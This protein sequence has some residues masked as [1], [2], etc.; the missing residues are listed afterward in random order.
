MSS[1]LETQESLK[2]YLQEKKVLVESYY[3][4][5]KPTFE[6]NCS[7]T[8]EVDIIFSL[9][10][11]FV[12]EFLEAYSSKEK[13]LRDDMIFVDNFLSLSYPSIN[14]IKTAS[15]EVTIRITVIRIRF[16]V[17]V[18]G[19]YE[20]VPKSGINK[21]FFLKSLIDEYIQMHVME[22]LGEYFAY[23]SFSHFKDKTFSQVMWLISL[24]EQ[25]N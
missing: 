2:N 14:N 8:K 5:F 18:K 10:D 13:I 20:K 24:L 7:F 15:K 1:K 21:L 22:I 12:K 23:P 6:S 3:G 11:M 4:K 25:Q 16:Q 9:L 19:N 17:V